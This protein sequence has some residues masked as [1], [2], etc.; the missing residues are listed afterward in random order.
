MK[1][2]FAITKQMFEVYIF[3]LAFQQS[4]VLQKNNCERVIDMKREDVKKA[5][6]E[7]GRKQ[8]ELANAIGV[9]EATLIHWFHEVDV[10]S[11]RETRILNGI[12]KLKAGKSCE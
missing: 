8:W 9:H 3:S 1:Q 4:F 6:K 5:L 12:E 7:I 10:R 11:E 2:M